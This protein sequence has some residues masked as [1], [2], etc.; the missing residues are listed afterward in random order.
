MAINYVTLLYTIFGVLVSKG[1][2]II[3]SYK[4]PILLDLAILDMHC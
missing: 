1:K 3:L 4:H 2:C